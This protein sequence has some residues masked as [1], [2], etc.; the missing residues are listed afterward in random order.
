M[1]APLGARAERLKRSSRLVDRARM[2]ADEQP[3]PGEWFQYVILTLFFSLLYKQ[4]ALG[5]VL[6]VILGLAWFRMQAVRWVVS[7]VPLCLA[8]VYTALA[9]VTAF[10]V[11]FGE[12]ASRTVQCVLVVGAVA[13]TCKYVAIID[14]RTRSRLLVKFTILNVVVL[15]H[16]VLYHVLRGQMVTWKYLFDT[17]FVLSSV[18]VIFF[19]YEDK[20]KSR[21]SAYWYIG[22]IA[23]T[24][25]V[26]LSGE[27]KAYVLLVALFFTSRASIIQKS[28]VATTAAAAA[29]LIVAALPNSYV[30]RQLTSGGNHA[31]ELSNRFFF[32]LR[33]F[34][35]QSDY[36]RTFVNRNAH[37]L[38]EQHPIFGVG[39]TGYGAWARKRYG[40]LTT[41]R[42]FSM[43]VHGEKN[44]VPAESGLIGIAVAIG[45]IASSAWRI[46]LALVAAGGSAAS[47]RQRLPLYLFFF[48]ISYCLVEAMDTSMLWVILTTGFTAASLRVEQVSRQQRRGKFR[49]SARRI[50]APSTDHGSHGTF[51]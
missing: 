31:G 33:D 9:T 28:T 1:A 46:G 25:I 32:S 44:R 36:V 20:V 15:V 49:A 26:L 16:L 37:Q 6:H 39:A 19:G 3:Y 8:I 38:F 47:S 50:Y 13:S 41:S 40:D 7:P 27:R 45:L 34:S 12:G 21:S 30:T 17:K 23:L 5:L 2:S 18:P 43:N 42:G 51:A 22:L 11:G 29:L 4:V 14:E 35:Y 24:A 10:L 48:C